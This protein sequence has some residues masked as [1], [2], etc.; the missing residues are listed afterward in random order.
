MKHHALVAAFSALAI[1]A[2]CSGK[3]KS[4]APS[5]A[6]AGA[7]AGTT[8]EPDKAAEPKGPVIPEAPS[9][10]PEH[11]VYSLVDN[12]LSAHLTRDGGLLIPAG[13]AGFAKYLRFGRDKVPWGIR[14]ERD[15]TP[16]ATM[17][18]KSGSIEVPITAA[19][20][21]GATPLRLRVFADAAGHMSIRV[22]GDKKTEVT[23]EFPEGWSVAE[24]TLPEGALKEGENE[25]AFFTSRKDVDVA[26][27]QIGGAAAGEKVPAIH[28]DG[29]LAFDGV[30]LAY[31]V[32]VP[33]EGKLTGDLAHLTCKVAVTATPQTGEPVSGE[34][35]GNG[36]AV[37]L[38]PLAGKVVRLELSAPEAEGCE[39]ARLAGASLVVPGEAP[40]V[41]RGD[42]PKYVILWI[43]DSLRADRVKS[44]TETA[45]PDVPVFEELTRS[46]ALFLQTYVQGNESKA[47]HASIWTGLYPAVHRMI[48]GKNSLDKSH[49]T[50][51]E[52]MDK[53]GMFLSGV[54][55]NGWIIP[56]RGFGDA[57][58]AYR[59]HIH[60][61]GGLAGEDLM[62][63]AIESVEGKTDPW[64]LYLG[65]IDTHVSWRAKEPWM[66][67][68]DAEPYSGPYKTTASGHDIEAIATGK[69]K[70]SDRDIT[71]IVAIYDSNVSYQD[72]L[73]GKLIAKLEEWGIRDQ[74]MI[75]I[76]ADHG[77]EQFE[78]GRVGHGGSLRDSLIHVPLLIHYPPLFPAGKIPEGAEVIDI[79]PTL[80]DAMGVEANEAWQ[81]Q[82]LLP[83][84]HGVG[85]GY[86][87]LSLASHNEV[88]HAGRIGP[89]KLWVAG[90]GTRGFYDLGTEPA[91]KTDVAGELHIP[92][93]FVTDALWMLRAYNKDWKKR[94]WGNPANVT[95]QFAA[96]MGE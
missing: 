87:R 94:V 3:E 6:T 21:R 12:R 1:G 52:V 77:D 69:K 42:K 9:R 26:W 34:L 37:D 53:A 81:G 51:D 47:S 11:A 61:G 71:R 85:A 22:N 86:P 88:W 72:D 24:A 76:T 41:E 65:T 46:S 80:A 83:L 62:G 44:F 91:E 13:S 73:L 79:V 39:G 16:V 29:A 60:D 43:M 5:G 66:S 56:R 64:F 19:Q 18:G 54:S 15:G 58:D 95:A 57:W 17:T 74:T 10:G 27:I 36:A 4:S 63:K 48:G 96:D 84:A 2:G 35:V 75:V 89:Y 28:A 23:A 49:Q 40:E 93:R 8:G 20:A 55:A 32:M 25:I 70:I 31:Y 38:S 50:I 59:N 82:S 78:V 30:G 33:P 67:K 7:P 14:K 90:G 45:R 68:Y 92:R